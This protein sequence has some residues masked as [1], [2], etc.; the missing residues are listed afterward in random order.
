MIREL[1]QLS[2]CPS[3]PLVFELLELCKIIQALLR[4]WFQSTQEI[5]N[6]PFRGDTESPWFPVEKMICAWGV[7]NTFVYLRKAN[8]NLFSIRQIEVGQDLYPW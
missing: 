5:R 6:L 3:H 8:L 2:M 7:S 4:K 1:C